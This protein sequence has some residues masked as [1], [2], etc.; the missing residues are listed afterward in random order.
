M[1]G[2]NHDHQGHLLPCGLKLL[3]SFERYQPT[4]TKATEEVRALG[5]EALYFVEICGRHLLQR[6]IL[7]DIAIETSCLESINWL[8]CSEM[9]GE[10]VVF[11]DIPTV[12]MN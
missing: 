6:L 12:A 11:K 5:L 2:L 7:S 4:E 8:I 1:R 3:S 10:W 9:T